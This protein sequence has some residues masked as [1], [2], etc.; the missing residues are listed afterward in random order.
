MS[1]KDLI[2]YFVIAMGIVFVA[3]GAAT[4]FIAAFVA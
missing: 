1:N 2:T 3:L 4:A